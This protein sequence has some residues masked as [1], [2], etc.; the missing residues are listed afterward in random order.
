MSLPHPE[1]PSTQLT[2]PPFPR[3]PAD[4][5]WHWAL[6]PWPARGPAGAKAGKWLGTLFSRKRNPHFSSK[7]KC[8][9]TCFQKAMPGGQ[10][11]EQQ[12]AET[13]K[14]Q[15]KHKPSG[16]EEAG[17][18]EPPLTECLSHAGGEGHPQRPC[19]YQ[20]SAAATIPHVQGDVHNPLPQE[21]LVQSQ[22]CQ[23]WGRTAAGCP[24]LHLGSGVPLPLQEA[25]RAG[26]SAETRSQRGLQTSPGL[27]ARSA[28][29][30]PRP[31]ELS[32]GQPAR[33]PVP[34][35]GP[36]ARRPQCARR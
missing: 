12:Q 24:A 29:A 34:A 16:S 22:P 2:L 31:R 20:G 26:S 17:P 11:P 21:H 7:T 35:A 3:A 25:P 1:G 30:G 36:A 5:H 18:E 6:R 8:P 32:H 28:V 4:T 10:T 27:T 14:W 13:Q 19:L 9:W 15:N 33:A 23:A